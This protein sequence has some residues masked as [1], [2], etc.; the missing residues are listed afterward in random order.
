MGEN[1]EDNRKIPLDECLRALSEG[2]V[3]LIDS[4][5]RLRI[6]NN[7]FE[8]NSRYTSG[9][10]SEHNMTTPL[11]YSNVTEIQESKE[12]YYPLS[13]IEATEYIINGRI[14]CNEAKE[15]YYCI[16][17]ETRKLSRWNGNRWIPATFEELIQFSRWRLAH[18]TCS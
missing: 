4:G 9:V 14:V 3:L 15:D 13:L 1:G 2:K 18:D 5:T 8:I 12:Y 7:R 16:D 11:T 6:R 17:K 10:W